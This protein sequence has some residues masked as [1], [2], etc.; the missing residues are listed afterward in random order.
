MF[1]KKPIS[2]LLMS[3]Q[4]I[5]NIG[6]I[7]YITVNHS[8]IIQSNLFLTAIA[9][10]VLAYEHNSAVFILSFIFILFLEFTSF[11]TFNGELLCQHYAQT[12]ILMDY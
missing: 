7:C 1:F 5:V 11:L 10:P 2:Y 3:L 8:A 9:K 6:K 12:L 4:N